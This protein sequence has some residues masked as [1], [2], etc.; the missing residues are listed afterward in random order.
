[1]SPKYWS[2]ENEPI[3]EKRKDKLGADK[4]GENQRKKGKRE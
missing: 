3:L 2:G 1:V 4:A